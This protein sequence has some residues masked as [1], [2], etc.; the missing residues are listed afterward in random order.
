MS[1]RGTTTSSL[2]QRY[3]CL[4]RDPSALCKRLKEIAWLASVA[5]KSFTGIET[6]PKETVSD[7][8]ARGAML[9][10]GFPSSRAVG[11]APLHRDVLRVPAYEVPTDEL[12]DLAGRVEADRAAD[13]HE[14]VQPGLAR[15]LDDRLERHALQQLAQPE[16]HFLPLLEGRRVQLGLIAGRFLP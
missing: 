14:D 9:P 15:G 5:E 2:A 4:S 7:A 11:H 13:R 16:R 3:C 12:A 8:M 1:S 6:S 10:S